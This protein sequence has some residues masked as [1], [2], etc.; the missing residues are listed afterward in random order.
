M[1]E[2]K[3]ALDFLATAIS[4]KVAP[5]CV[6]FGSER[7]LRAL[8]RKQ[9]LAA[10]THGDQDADSSIAV[11]DGD[12]VEYRDVADELSTVALFGG[13]GPRVAVVEDADKFIEKH[14]TSLE[15]YVAKPRSTG[16]LILETDSF[17]SNTRLFKA[18]AESGLI[19]DCRVPE[20]AGSKSKNKPID[21]ARVVKW[22]AAWGKSRHKIRLSS[23]SAEAVYQLVGP[24]FG[25]LDQELAKLALFVPENGAVETELVHDVVGGWRTKTAW[26]LNGAIADGNAALALEQLDR[27]IQ[28]GQDPTALFGTISWSLRRFAAAARLVQESERRGQRVDRDTIA[29]A[30]G[31]AGFW[32]DDAKRAE[33]QLKQMGRHRAL[34]LYRWLL[35]IDLGLK[36]SHSN[37]HAARFLLEHLCVRL[38]RKLAPKP[39]VK[40]S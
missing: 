7:F 12:S 27:L 32:G 18:V 23:E 24:E 28:A 5:V 31:K 10:L 1:A 15:G 22:L 13:G 16:V 25:L 20:I 4:G 21:D 37:E 3:H 29:S 26:D 30:I 38:S 39:P 8:V 2:T 11:F 19:V 34:R 33:A 6:L 9:L 14:R 17:P 35:E 40:A 36:G